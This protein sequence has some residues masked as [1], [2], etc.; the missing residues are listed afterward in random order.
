MIPPTLKKAN[1]DKPED[2]P[3][4]S[5]ILSL[6]IEKSLL[7]MVLILRRSKI[8]EMTRNFLSRICHNTKPIASKIQVFSY[9]HRALICLS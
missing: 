8:D 9:I 6:P 4:I 1:M 3:L 2:Y 5:M 7:V